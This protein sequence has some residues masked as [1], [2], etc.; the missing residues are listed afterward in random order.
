[1]ENENQQN[2]SAPQQENAP[3]QNKQP[4]AGNLFDSSA[5]DI[6]GI[7]KRT[8]GIFSKTLILYWGLVLMAMLPSIVFMIILPAGVGMAI[9]GI[10]NSILSVMVQGCVAYAVFQYAVGNKPGFGDALSKGFSHLVPLL[11]TAIVIGVAVGVGMILL[12]VP[13]IIVLCIMYVAIPACVVERLGVEG[14]IRR[15]M[16]LTQGYR[17]KIFALALIVGIASVIIQL[18]IPAVLGAIIPVP[19]FIVILTIVVS[20]LPAAFGAVMAAV[21]YQELRAIKDGSSM[22]SLAKV[23]D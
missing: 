10:L 3:A 7:L 18:T 13:G 14:S 6:A 17:L 1:M 22:E 19:I 5:F 23:F 9:G 21:V 16:D 15:S 20:S 11:L 2:N 12:V 8:W 4:V